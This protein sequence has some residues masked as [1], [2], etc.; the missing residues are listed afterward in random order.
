MNAKK[1]VIAGTM[2]GRKN[3]DI[4]LGNAAGKTQSCASLA[5][6]SRNAVRKPS[7]ITG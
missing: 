6:A 3:G 2:D 4:P 1:P 7:S 5:A